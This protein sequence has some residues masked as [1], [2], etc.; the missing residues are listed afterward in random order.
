VAKIG[1]TCPF[2]HKS[3]KE[4]ALYRGRHYCLNFYKQYRDY[5]G[6]S[7]ALRS[8]GSPA[9]WEWR[10][11]WAGAAGEREA[12]LKI[13]LKVIDMESGET[14]VCDLSEAKT[15]DWSNSKMMRVIGGL[16]ITSWDKLIEILS[17]RAR[18]GYREVEVYEGSIFM[19]L[20]GG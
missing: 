18:K 19:F 6:E 16:Q 15:W 11:P 8:G 7:S 10:E 12:E 2:T 1:V 4:C 14:R 20:G 17:Y 9:M 13:R 3:C 5:T